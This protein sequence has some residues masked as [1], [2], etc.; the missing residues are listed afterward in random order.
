M[1]ASKTSKRTVLLIPALVAV[2]IAVWILAVWVN[3]QSEA[4]RDEARPADAIVVLGAAE[5][6]GHPSEVLRARLD[7]ALSLYRRHLAPFVVLTGGAGGDPHF[8]EAGVGRRYLLARGVPAGA[9]VADAQGYSTLSS[10]RDVAALMHS[11]GWRSAILVSDGY[12]IFRARRMFEEQG[13]LAFGSPRAPTGSA[14]VRAFLG[15]RQAVG[16][17]LWKLGFGQ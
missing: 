7:H 17:V 8:T 9:V 12:H 11:R 10:A 4:A 1:A 15:L 16:Y 14:I 13:V 2:A 3:V 6:S 5:Y